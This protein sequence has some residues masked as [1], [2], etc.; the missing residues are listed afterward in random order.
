MDLSPKVFRAVNSESLAALDPCNIA[1][2][3]LASKTLSLLIS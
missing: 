3:S 1:V 2:A